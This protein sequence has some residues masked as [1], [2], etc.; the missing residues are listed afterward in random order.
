MFA[1]YCLWCQS[2]ISNFNVS[3]S[4]CREESLNLQNNSLNADSYGWDFCLNDFSALKSSSNLGVVSSLNVGQGFKLIQD[5]GSWFGFGVSRDNNKLF[6]FD[7]G[8]SPETTP[9]VVDLGNPG[10]LLHFPEGFDLIKANGNW[11]AFIGSLDFATASKGIVRLDFGVS[12]TN[13]PTAVNVGNF[14]YDTRFRNLKLIRQNADLILLLVS[15]N[16]DGVSAG[17]G[18]TLIRINYRNA[19][20]NLI[21]ASDI[22]DTGFITG[23]NLPIGL[24]VARIGTNWIAHVTSRS[25]ST[26]LQLNFGV[27]ILSSP[28]V[29]GNYSFSGVSSPVGIRLIQEGNQYFALVSNESQPYSIVNFKDLQPSSTPVEVL[30]SGATGLAGADVIRWMGKGIVW[31]LSNTTNELKKIVY[32]SNCGASVQYS[33]STTPIVSYS[34]NGTKWIELAAWQSGLDVASISSAAV[35]ISSSIAPDI[36]FTTDGAI[37]AQGN[38]SFISSSI[39]SSIN[40]FAWDFGDSGTSLNPNPVH[41]FASAGSYKVKLVVGSTNGCTN[42]IVNTITQY[43]QPVTNFLLPSTSP[44]CTN[45]SYIFTNTSSFDTSSNPS[46]QWSVNGANVSVNQDLSY[47]FSTTSPQSIKLTASIPGCSSQ[48]TQTINSLLAGPLVDFTLPPN[49]CQSTSLSLTNTTSGSVTSYAWNFGDGNTSSSTNAVNTYTNTGNYNIT[50]QANNAAGCQNSVTKPITIYSKP[51]ANFSIGL[52]PFSCA[53]T[54]SQF[55]DTTPSPTDSNLTTWNWNFGDSNNGTSTFKNPTYT[56][57]TSNNYNVSLTVG[58][59]FGCSATVQKSITIS[60]SPVASFT[61]SAACVNQVTQ[62]TDASSGT[63][64]SRQWQIQGN[65]FSAPNPQFTFSSS[66]T[67][68][69]QLTAN[70][71]N[72]CI[73]QTTKNIVV[74]IAP[75][76]DFTIQSPCANSATTFTEVTNTVDPVVSQGWV[77]GS[78]ANG[79]GSPAQFS[80]PT[81]NTYLVKLNSARQSG[82]VYTVSKNVSIISP[83]IADFTTSVDTGPA[84]LNVSFVNNSIQANSYQ[85]TFGDKNNSTSALLNPSFIFSDL[86]D[87]AVQLK[88]T[89]AF[90]CSNT[91][92]RIV[93][94]VIPKIDLIMNDFYLTNDASG[95]LQ[96][97]ISILSKSN[98]TVT[99]PVVLITSSDGAQIKK[100]IIGTLKPNQELIQQLDFLIMPRTSNYLCAEVIAP[101]NV[102]LFLNRKCL[103]INGDEILFAPFPNPTKSQLN[104]DW[105][106]VDGSDVSFQIINS[107]GTIYLQQSVS[108]ILKGINRLVVNTSNLASGVY[109]IRFKDSKKDK[110]FSFIVSGN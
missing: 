80:F 38:V 53:G 18:G 44:F 54:S 28:S 76:L 26:I 8:N 16:S 78:L 58:T 69:V 48:A 65:I 62:F 30:T 37:C 15:F 33:T 91:F 63:I 110:A 92:S 99:D 60:P 90:N 100:K 41:V 7:F 83:P 108:G 52:P 10:G 43:S 3:P 47:L 21:S 49:G 79:S 57:S 61:N 19:F 55:T 105:I 89:N 45:Q 12:I 98:V 4:F 66:N 86:G 109:L 46:W 14:G 75:S 101:G 97:T 39:S 107:S 88:A 13:A 27:D 42:F 81:P 1:S 32:E 11:V 40:S 95:A 24:N 22:F 94:V 59:N 74:P 71:T 72:G 73:G 50:L 29:E 56:Y 64:Q 77:F 17:T 93:S 6:R 68:P 82:C 34:T 87:Y 104:L 2:P 20:T 51:Q 102:D 5:N 106:S 70:G 85:W 9:D 25:A 96:P 67:F 84:P 35:S 23:A 103:T 36:A 31:G